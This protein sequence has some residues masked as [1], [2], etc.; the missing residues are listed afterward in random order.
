MNCE[1]SRSL[2]RK[3]AEGRSNRDEI[4]QLKE[5]C[6]SCKGCN[7]ELTAFEDT[8]SALKELKNSKMPENLIERINAAVDDFAKENKKKTGFMAFLP[9]MPA[10]KVLIP[11]F[12][13]AAV[14]VF[15]F[16]N[17]NVHKSEKLSMIKKESI[18]AP[19]EQVKKNYQ[20]NVSL[21]DAKYS[22]DIKKLENVIL[23]S[24]KTVNDANTD[25]KAFLGSDTNAGDYNIIAKN[26]ENELKA[27]NLINIENTSKIKPVIL[28][29]ALRLHQI[30]HLKQLKVLEQKDDGLL[31]KALNIKNLPA[32]DKLT[33]DEENSDRRLLAGIY[34]ELILMQKDNNGKLPENTEREILKMMGK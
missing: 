23:V 13:L 17:G 2:I 1:N 8:V 15:V 24:A 9:A 32:I 21:S 22:E 6:S 18:E 12:A 20:A 25:N 14:L 27:V 16:N 10:F 28:R 29:R 33:V 30:E 7:E 26:L 34:A 11:F 5:H 19:S 3:Y 31:Y 4:A